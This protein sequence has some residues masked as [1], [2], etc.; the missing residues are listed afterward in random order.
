MHFLFFFCDGG[1]VTILILPAAGFLFIAI[2]VKKG[3]GEGSAP[4]PYFKPSFAMWG[5]R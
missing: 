1:G 3:G 4:R 5:K 2:A